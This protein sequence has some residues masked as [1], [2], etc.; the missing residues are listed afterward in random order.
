MRVITR[1]FAAIVITA[2]VLSPAFA[3]EKQ[4]P[5]EREFCRLDRNSDREL[6]FEEFAACEF[7]K[8]EHLKQLP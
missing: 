4:D 8:L 2:L 3:A 5:S 7:Y 6:T 1:C